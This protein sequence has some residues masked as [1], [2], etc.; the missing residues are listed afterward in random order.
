MLTRVFA[1]AVRTLE[2]GGRIAVN[3][4]N[5]GRKPYRSLSADVIGIL[6]D[7]LGLLLRGEVIWL[8]ARGASGSCAWGSFQSPANPVLRDV[9]E[10]VDRGQ[11]G[12]V[13]PCPLRARRRR[14]SGS[15]PRSRCPRTSSSRPPPTSGRSPPRGHPRRVT[16]RRSPSSCP[17]GSSSSTPTA[18]DLVLD[19][20][21]GSGTTG[22]G[23][24]PDRT[25]VRGLRHRDVV[26]RD[27]RAADP[28]RTGSPMHAA[29]AETPRRPPARAAV[30]VLRGGGRETM[31]PTCWPERPGRAQGAGAGPG[32]P[33]PLRIRR[34][35]R[36]RQ[37]R[38]RHRGQLLG[39]RR[40]GR[41][42]YFDVSGAFTTTGRA[43]DGPTLCGR[44]WARRPSSHASHP[45]VPFVLVTTDAPVA[46]SAGDQALK[47]LRRPDRSRRLRRRLRRHRDG[48]GDG[49]GPPAAYASKGPDAAE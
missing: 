43:C 18:D 34:P 41:R 10:R 26:R 12:P 15:R 36:R 3:V 25:A 1:E 16:R 27:R 8:K 19:P 23:R 32:A 44:R 2:P 39:G 33:R 49:S 29:A 30:D 9:T 13:R 24:R 40:T 47:T 45:D 11:Q 22:G 21:M 42:W 5:L 14:R 46:G 35:R 6:Q 31:P 20:F 37:D 28:G 7:E 17:C 4:A 38:R 48:V